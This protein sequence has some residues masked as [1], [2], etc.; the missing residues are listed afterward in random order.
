MNSTSFDDFMTVG[1]FNQ[2]TGKVDLS[3]RANHDHQR[4]NRLR[5]PPIHHP[6]QII[7]D[8]A[9]KSLGGAGQPMGPAGQPPLV[10]RCSTAFK[11]QS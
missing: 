9:E 2:K 8:R 7:K 5:G 1:G 6:G 4:R 3:V 10:H 11:D